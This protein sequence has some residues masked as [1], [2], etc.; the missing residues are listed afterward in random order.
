MYNL[1][2]GADE[3][4]NKHANKQ[5]RIQASVMVPCMRQH[6]KGK[7]FTWS[8]LSINKRAAGNKDMKKKGE[9]E[10]CMYVCMYTSLLPRKIPERGWREQG[11]EG[12]CMY[13]A[14]PL[15]H[16]G[17]T[18]RGKGG[19]GG[20]EEEEGRLGGEEMGRRGDGKERGR[21]GDGEESGSG[22][23]EIGVEGRG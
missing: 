4:A 5:A 20:E 6:T 19:G 16:E 15:N 10:E 23:Q 13:V 21:R 7:V 11:R 22:G 17:E 3:L 2:F 9:N 18:E 1:L 14:N 8:T 12:I